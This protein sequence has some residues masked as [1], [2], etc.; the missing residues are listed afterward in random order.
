MVQFNF[1]ELGIFE[2]SAK[3]LIFFK[4]TKNGTGEMAWQIRVHTALI[5][6]GAWFSDPH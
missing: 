2:L 6:D 3:I 4:T 1:H 5:E